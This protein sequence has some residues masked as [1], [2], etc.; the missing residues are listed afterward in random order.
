M[1]DKILEILARLQETRD[2]DFSGYKRT[3]IERRIKKR[4]AARKVETYSEYIG[5]LDLDPSEYDKLMAA[6]YINVT[7]FFRDKEAFKLIEEV[8]LPVIIAAQEAC[9]DKNIR[10]WC[11]GS[12]SGEEVYSLGMLLAELLGNRF[13][14]Y[15]IVIY[16]TD[17]DSDT[18]DEARCAIYKAN[19]VE[20][21]PPSM[22]EKYFVQSKDCGEYKICDKIRSIAKFGVLTL[23]KEAPISRIDLLMCRNVLIYF[24]K[25]LQQKVLAQFQYALNEGGFLVLGKAESPLKKFKNFSK[26]ISRTWKIYQKLE[27][28]ESCKI[29]GIGH[30][31]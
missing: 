12:A 11:P 21:V 31:E 30:G 23:G 25:E 1:A 2:L 24:S 6:I 4:L 19:R 22:L 7:G 26:T 29:K 8:V 18:V 15:N 28:E 17:A 13:N 20:H 27:T 16:G 5:I 14:E 3:I 9:E 10:I